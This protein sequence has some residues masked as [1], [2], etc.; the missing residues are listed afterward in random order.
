VSRTTLTVR[1]TVAQFEALFNT[2]INNYRSPDG[3]VFYSVSSKPTI[4]SSIPATVIG[5]IGLSSPTQF[6][7]LAKVFKTLGETP[8][9]KPVPN[10]AG[11]TGPGGAYSAADLRTAYQIPSHLGAGTPQTV[12]VFEQGGFDANDVQ[13]YLTTNKLPSVPVKARNV[14]GYGG[15]IN[16]LSIELE[17]VLD[18]K[19]LRSLIGIRSKQ[20]Q[21]ATGIVLLG[22]VP[23]A[24]PKRKGA[25]WIAYLGGEIA[26]G[27]STTG[28]QILLSPDLFRP[29]IAHY[30][31]LTLRRLADHQVVFP[32]PSPAEF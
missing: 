25:F 1:G 19:R 16:D 18:I 5:I 2:Q 3:K 20:L 24:C 12:A 4:P 22:S 14:N 10:T 13:Q 8:T 7:P 17:A 30:S 26:C 23:V 6:A 32:V 29:T 11:G 31:T 28:S 9:E 27:Q 21:P 15:G